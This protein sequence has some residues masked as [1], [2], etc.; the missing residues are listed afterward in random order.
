M[1]KQTKSTF[2]GC[3]TFWLSL[4]GGYFFQFIALI[5]ITLFVSNSTTNSTEN[6]LK[7]I[8]VNLILY[9][10]LYGAILLIC[11]LTN[12][13][14]KELFK[15]V[16]FKKVLIYSTISAATFFM[17]N[18]I[19]S[20]ISSWLI[21]LGLTPTTLTFKL[22]TKNYFIALI[23]IVL[24]PAVIEE[25]LFRGIIFSNISKHGKT[26]ATIITTLMF[27]LFHTSIFQTIY[28]ILFGLLLCV[29]IY[30]EDNIYYCII[31][32]T[33]NNFLALTSAFFNWQLFSSALWF[34]I[35]ACI[36][37]II[38]VTIISYA[39]TKQK[40]KC[41]KQPFTPKDKLALILTF[42]ALSAM[43]VYSIFI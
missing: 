35:L 26:S 3:V 18:P 37:A 22:T 6:L 11:L 34:T 8:Y 17:L 16:S 40:D 25:I 21:N 29:I 5:M 42:A 15:K 30:R 4:L 9:L 38:Y 32:H 33:I 28:P 20:C 23:F 31:A 10:A 14:K 24:L 43:L 13:P 27:S 12:K 41:E 1:N 7:N 39:I 36:L 2:K 19:I